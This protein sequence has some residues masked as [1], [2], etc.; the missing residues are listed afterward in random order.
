MSDVLD[1]I[2]DAGEAPSTN[3]ADVSALAMQ[4]LKLEGDVARL[5]A[6]LKQAKKDLMKVSDGE[7]PAALKAAGMPSFTLENGMI[8]SYREDMK[9]SVP[10]T[11]KAFVLAQMKEWGFESSVTNTFTIDLGK[12]NG[13]SA[14]VLQGQAEEMGL[15]AVIAEDIAT[16]TVKKVLKQ[17][18]DAGKNDELAKFGAFQF[19]RATV[20]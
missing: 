7:L 17:R 19:T 5:E 16:G 9:V 18:N 4:Q 11:K 1:E 20:K 2:A 13:N 6:D 3:L 8:V 15:T 10:A 14:K 12:G